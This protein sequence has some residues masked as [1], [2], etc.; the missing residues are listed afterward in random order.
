[1]ELQELSWQGKRHRSGSRGSRG[2]QLRR[3][4]ERPAGCRGGAGAAGGAAGGRPGAR[5]TRAQ[6]RAGRGQRP[7]R[8][9]SL[10]PPARRESRQRPSA[11]KVSQ[12]GASRGS[13]R[14]GRT[15]GQA[16]HH[17]TSTGTVLPVFRISSGYSWLG[18]KSLLQENY[19]TSTPY[20]LISNTY[21][22]LDISTFLRSVCDTEWYI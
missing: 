15:R 4:V 14:P 6:G 13:P 18:E 21:F 12:L 17:A 22:S 7:G 19:V 3:E 11:T 1:M 20:F 16:E 10:L 8:A 2:R 5:A 9:C